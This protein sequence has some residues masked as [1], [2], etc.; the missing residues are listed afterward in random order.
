VVPRGD[1]AGFLAAVSSHL[2]GSGTS[3]DA[4]KLLVADLDIDGRTI[5]AVA[6]AGPEELQDR[7][8]VN[9]PQA[10]KICSHYSD[11]TRAAE[12]ET[13]APEDL[14]EIT[15]DGK[16]LEKL[17]AGGRATAVL[18]LIFSVEGRCLII[19]Q[20]EDDLDNSFIYRGVVRMIRA[21]KKPAASSRQ[22]IAAT[23]NPNI[24]V[25]GDA[26]L[27]MIME[28]DEKQARVAERGSIDA[29]AVRDRI[30]ALLE[31]GEDAFRRRAER[32]R[33][34]ELARAK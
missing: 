16:P 8:R 17:S 25:N 30:C 13:M 23:H 3:T 19:D 31:G 34:L 15:L 28:A 29:G 21:D 24:P 18:Y 2:Q 12:L 20:P 4:K 14:I 1:S 32:Y 22:V 26:D 27:V 5:A 7:F 33:S 6:A 11:Q 10:L 9:R